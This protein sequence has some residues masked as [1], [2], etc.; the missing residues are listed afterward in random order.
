MVGSISVVFMRFFFDSGLPWARGE[1][2]ALAALLR[3]LHANVPFAIWIDRAPATDK[4][5][6]PLLC[7]AEA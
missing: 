1:R 7:G 6:Y 3:T 5:S 4:Q 2:G